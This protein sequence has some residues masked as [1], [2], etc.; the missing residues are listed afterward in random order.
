MGILCLCRKCDKNIPQILTQLRATSLLEVV[1]PD[2]GSF[3]AL[4]KEMVKLLAGR[5]R[6][7][8]TNLAFSR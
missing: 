2:P 4:P 1:V 6:A 3:R 8:S 7:I 5:A